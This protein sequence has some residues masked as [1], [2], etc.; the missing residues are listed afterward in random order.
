MNVAS[1]KKALR[2]LAILAIA[3]LALTG[4]GKKY[5]WHQKIVL[6]VETP[7]GVVTGGSVVEITMRWY[8]SFASMKGVSSNKRGEA[9][10][11]EVAP[12]RYLFVPLE[13][14]NYGLA[15]G[16]FGDGEEFPK[17]TAAK[18]TGLH[19]TR[20]VPRRLWRMLITFT[21]IGNPMTVREVDPDDLA[22]TFGPGYQLKSLTL[23]ITD[24]P[25]TRGEVQKVLWWLDDGQSLKPIWPDLTSKERILLSSVNWRT[26]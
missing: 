5:S 23:E 11:V 20:P 22:A 14:N 3:G 2:R 1:A 12:G 13:S 4:C 24:E 16:T 8:E 9:S 15:F 19:E 25:V 6:E 18:L 17:E 21:D 26:R 7:D 10:F